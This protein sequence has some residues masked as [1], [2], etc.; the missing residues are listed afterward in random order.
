[1]KNIII[2][3][4]TIFLSVSSIAYNDIQI[5][6]T[7]QQTFLNKPPVLKVLSQDKNIN[8]ITG[9]Y[10]W[11]ANN[12]DGTKT[13]VCA[14]SANPTELVKESAPLTVSAKSMLTLCF[15]D[16]PSNIKVNI[17]KDNKSIN[18]EISENKIEVPESKGTLIYEVIAT[19]NKGTVS[20][21]FLINVN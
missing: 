14:D 5:S 8:A 4:I 7:N 19:W 17:W 10:S 11:T 18:Q 15:N 6:N 20:Y 9:T 1:M 16:K 3:L 2:P 12:N 13:T 21:V